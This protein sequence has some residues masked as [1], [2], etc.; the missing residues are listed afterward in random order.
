MG[1]ALI[2]PQ[3]CKTESATSYVDIRSVRAVP[4]YKSVSTT[5]NGHASVKHTAV[6][7]HALWSAIYVSDARD[8]SSCTGKRR[9]Y[10]N[11]RY[12]TNG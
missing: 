7:C 4:T 8:G 1:S 10:G 11:G 3:T 9:S 5:R 2:L 12:A 6:V